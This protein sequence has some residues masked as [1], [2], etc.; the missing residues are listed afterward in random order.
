MENYDYL[1]PED[2]VDNEFY[3]AEL[4][5]SNLRKKPKCEHHYWV[6]KCS[7]CGQ[8]LGSETKPDIILDI[9][10]HKHNGN[11]SSK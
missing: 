4:H 10:K 2:V 6:C 11:T 1:D 3:L 5:K 9:L 8:I 7:I